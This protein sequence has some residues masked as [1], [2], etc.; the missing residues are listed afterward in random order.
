MTEFERLVLLLGCRATLILGIVAALYLLAGRRW[1]QSCTTWVRLG[2]IALL[3]M[4]VGA[5]A[6]PTIGIPILSAAPQT[7]AAGSETAVGQDLPEAQTGELPSPMS[8]L[9]AAGALGRAGPGWSPAKT[10]GLCLAA[11]YGLV[12]V[13]LAIRFVI[14]CQGLDQLRRASAI[15]SDPAWQATLARWSR[16]LQ[17]RR[18]VELRSADNVSVPMT[19]G[20]RVP[21]I[22]VPNDCLT[23]GDQTGC[24]KTQREAIL[25]HELTHIA[26]SDFFWQALTQVTALLYW[27]HPLVWLIRRQDGALRERICDALCSRHLSREVYAQALVRIAGRRHF[28]PATALGM[29]MA[30]PSSLR[31]RLNDLETGAEARFSIPNRLQRAFLSG[32]AALGLG[33]IVVGTLTTRGSAVGKDDKS[34]GAP[35]AKKVPATKKDV[36]PIRLP[37]TIEGQVVDQ[38]DKPVPKAGVTVLIR[39]FNPYVDPADASAPKPWTA[40]TDDRGRYTISTGELTLGPDDEVRI[41]V[42]AEGFADLSQVDYERRLAKGKLPVQKLHTGRKVRGRI[43]DPDGKPIEAAIIR[44]HVE[45]PDMSLLWD[46][47]PLP[48]DKPGAFSFSIPR[49]GTAAFVIYPRGF[50]PRTVY[51]SDDGDDLGAIQVQTGTSLTGR[52]V[53]RKGNGVAG[54]VVAI[55]GDELLG[56]LVRLPIGTAVKT[57][58]TGRFTLPPVRGIYTVRVTDHAPDYTRQL[59]ESGV[60]PPPI[61]PERIDFSGTDKTEDIEFREAA[62][63]TMKGTLRWADGSGVPDIQIRAEMLP[64]TWASGVELDSARTDAEGRYVLRV[65]APVERVIISVSQSIRAADGTYPQPRAVGNGANAVD[66]FRNIKFDLLEDNVEDADFEV[67]ATK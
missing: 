13:V 53:D 58:E 23:A 6:L 32:T 63:V 47:G 39:R 33:L 19:F 20:W 55:L 27:V 57:D 54:T 34:P 49:A 36:A 2:I 66:Q 56:R 46:S 65:P 31:R 60:K 3:A 16:V 35:A 28:R 14:A 40:T 38:Q 7:L 24:D 50:A 37:D 43:V 29:A 1:P 26:R 25:I 51:V 67:G 59:V 17:V 18:P 8:S 41:K 61:L 9:P 15:V 12:V 5:W 22:L 64:V 45:T 30:H 44:F 11:A 48:V 21:V 52:V 4:P 42:R 10:L 62:A